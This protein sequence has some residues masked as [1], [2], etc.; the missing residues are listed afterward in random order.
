MSSNISNK[1]N[2]ETVGELTIKNSGT[3]WLE[4]TSIKFSNQD[5]IQLFAHDDILTAS[6]SPDHIKRLIRRKHGKTSIKQ[7][8]IDEVNSITNLHDKVKNN[9]KNAFTK[10]YEDMMVAVALS[11][12]MRDGRS[13]YTYKDIGKHVLKNPDYYTIC[14]TAYLMRGMFER[15]HFWKVKVEQKMMKEMN[16][17]YT[18]GFVSSQKNYGCFSNL[19]SE[20][21]TNKHRDLNTRFKNKHGFRIVQRSK[22]H[23]ETVGGRLR[24]DNKSFFSLLKNVQYDENYTGSV[25]E[26]IPQQLNFQ[27]NKDDEVH[28][29]ILENIVFPVGS[30]SKVFFIVGKWI[31]D[32]EEASQNICETEERIDGSD[33]RHLVNVVDET[34][35]NKDV[36][37]QLDHSE[38]EKARNKH[39]RGTNKRKKLG[40]VKRNKNSS[41]KRKIITS[42][43]ESDEESD[44]ESVLKQKKEEEE[45]E[46]FLK[47]AGKSDNEMLPDSD[48]NQQNAIV[49]G[50]KVKQQ[51][52][53]TKQNGDVTDY[54]K[55]KELSL[56]MTMQKH[57]DKV[58]NDKKEE[59]RNTEEEKRSRTKHEIR[60]LKVS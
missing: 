48:S 52:E 33:D 1:V 18:N 10:A 40:A 41:K 50:V 16:Y 35:I 29:D 43:T 31:G 45:F 39:A 47:H 38:L 24:P 6:L 58:E 51:K 19:I 37:K 20:V 60:K 30:M 28:F 4:K 21:V 54:L 56:I 11:I 17:K 5:E 8:D 14:R 44:S 57:M 12:G 42:E 23:N 15:H 59:E 3:Y 36:R 46:I 7:N 26:T 49:K 27:K 55:K 22:K 53:K 34:L 9:F 25:N 13:K 32:F 2:S